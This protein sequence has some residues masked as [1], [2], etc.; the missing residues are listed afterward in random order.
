MTSNGKAEHKREK[1]SDVQIQSLK[2]HCLGAVLLRV[3]S[4]GHCCKNLYLDTE[5]PRVEGS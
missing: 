3:S 2:E 5:G 4:G 1:M